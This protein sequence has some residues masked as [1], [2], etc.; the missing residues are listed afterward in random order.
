MFPEEVFILKSVISVMQLLVHRQQ[1]TIRMLAAVVVI[2]QVLVVAAV[3][4][5]PQRQPL[6][7]RLLIAAKAIV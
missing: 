2:V 6:P 3:V 1:P 7:H 4:A 5:L